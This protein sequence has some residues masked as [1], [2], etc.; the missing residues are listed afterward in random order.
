VGIEQRMVEWETFASDE[1]FDVILGSDVLYATS[2]HARLRAICEEHLAPGGRVL[3]SD[4]FRQQSLPML[5]GMD[6]EGWRVT[7]SRWSIRV[8]TGDRAIAVYDLS[9]R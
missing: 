3:F 2:L 6:A 4:P 5:E 9:R 1:P 8:E 7:L